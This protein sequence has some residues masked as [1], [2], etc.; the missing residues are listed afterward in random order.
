MLTSQVPAAAAVPAVFGLT[1]LQNQLQVIFLL[2]LIG[3][4]C[5]IL[6]LG[7]SH[8]LGKGATVIVIALLGMLMLGLAA[9]GTAGLAD[10]GS[11]MAAF[12]KN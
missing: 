1:E 12:I 3:L 5:Y 10:I 7:F 6:Y 11:R 2:L 8:K 4:A 9:G